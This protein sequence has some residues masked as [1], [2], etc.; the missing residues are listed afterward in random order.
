MPLLLARSM[1]AYLRAVYRHH[2][3]GRFVMSPESRSHA[4]L[5]PLVETVH[6][7]LLNHGHTDAQSTAKLVV[8]HDPLLDDQAIAEV[9]SLVHSRIGGLGVLDPFLADGT[10]DEVMINGMGDLWVERHGRL[11]CNRGHR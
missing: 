2:L 7:Q 9:V 8:G 6:Q 3:G 11:E 10:V 5:A 4:T 1:P